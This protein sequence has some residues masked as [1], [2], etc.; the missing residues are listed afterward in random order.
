MEVIGDDQVVTCPG[1]GRDAAKLF[2]DEAGSKLKASPEKHPQFLGARDNR[3]KRALAFLSPRASERFHLCFKSCR[4]S[5]HLC[6]KNSSTLY[7][8]AVKN[9]VA[10]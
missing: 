2:L 8:R 9:L 1:S 4:H 10:G 3:V 5:K 6:V 7:P